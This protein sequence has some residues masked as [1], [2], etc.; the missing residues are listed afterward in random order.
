MWALLGS[1]GLCRPQKVLVKSPKVVEISI[2]GSSYG[3]WVEQVIIE[4]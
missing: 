3:R 4:L 2:V 1:E